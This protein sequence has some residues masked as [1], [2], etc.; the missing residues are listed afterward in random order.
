V[1]AFAELCLATRPQDHLYVIEWVA[2]VM[3]FCLKSKEIW[4]YLCRVCIDFSKKMIYKTDNQVITE[5]ILFKKNVL[6]T[7]ANRTF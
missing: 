2:K 1:E 3:P 7:E 5:Y 6:S 4:K